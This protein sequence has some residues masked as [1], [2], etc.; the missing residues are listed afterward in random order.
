MKYYILYNYKSGLEAIVSNF[1]PFIDDNTASI[2]AI[3]KKE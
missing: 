1:F 3:N 2:I